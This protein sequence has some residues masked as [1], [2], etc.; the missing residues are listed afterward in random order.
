VPAIRVQL[1]DA[2]DRTVYTTVISPPV[3]E[4]EP[5]ASTPFNGGDVDVPR[6]ATTIR[7]SF[8]PIA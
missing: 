5:G 7:F 6:S 2:Q 4:L 1:R 3:S 8:G